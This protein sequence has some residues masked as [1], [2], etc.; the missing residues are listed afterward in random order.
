METCIKTYPQLVMIGESS[1]FILG[2]AL[3]FYVRSVINPDFNFKKSQLQAH[4]IP[5]FLFWFF[6]LPQL[7]I[8]F[9]I[10]GRLFSTSWNR[11]FPF[12]DVFI[13]FSIFTHFSAYV[14]STI[15]YIHSYRRQLLE[16]YSTVDDVRFRWLA[17][18]LVSFLISWL[19]GVVNYITTLYIDQL[20]VFTITYVVS[21]FIFSNMIVVR[22]LRYPNVF[23][24]FAPLNSNRPKYSKNSLSP[25][26]IVDYKERLTTYMLDNK[27]FTNPDLTLDHMAQALTVPTHIVSQVLNVGFQQNFYQFVNHYRIMEFKKL[28]NNPQKQS[29]T[30]LDACY[31]S[32][33]NS[34]TTF[35]TTFKKVTGITPTEYL[36]TIKSCQK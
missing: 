6:F 5:F 18:L 31:R 27:A 4:L 30:I 10:E 26:E 2:P 13:H 25:E 29:M 17:L 23:F 36:K 22:G 21:V 8:D 24:D 32:G 11:I 7:Q 9:S 35:N 33:F 14:I 15:L 3:Y 20:R 28:L 19:I 12:E 1:G 16:E 34:K